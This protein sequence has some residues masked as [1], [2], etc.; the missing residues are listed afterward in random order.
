MR[1]VHID[2]VF[3][4]ILIHVCFCMAEVQRLDV[5]SHDKEF[6][7]L[8]TAYN[9]IIDSNVRFLFEAELKFN[10]KSIKKT[11]FMSFFNKNASSLSAFMQ[12]SKCPIDLT[13]T[14]LKTIIAIDTTRDFSYFNFLN[15][16]F[17]SLPRLNLK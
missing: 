4:F 7:S 13:R 17:F 8:M 3:S 1:P 16:L 10:E 5:F 6:F 15:F 12:T 9:L 14:H 2:I 11:H